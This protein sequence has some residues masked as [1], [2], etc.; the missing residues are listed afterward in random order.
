MYAAPKGSTPLSSKPP[1]AL[2]NFGRA[3]RLQK[4]APMSLRPRVRRPLGLALYGLPMLGPGDLVPDVKVWAD[5]REEAKPLGELL[6]PGWS[7]LLFY[8]FDWSPG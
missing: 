1:Y 7:L 2:V 8:L 5:L 4:G 6:G 3:R